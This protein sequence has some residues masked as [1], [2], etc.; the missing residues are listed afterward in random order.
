MKFEYSINKTGL[1]IRL[2][3]AT[4]FTVSIILLASGNISGMTI[5]L[6]EPDT[7][8]VKVVQGGESKLK[9]EDCLTTLIGPGVNQ[10]DSFP[11]W[12]GFVGWVSPVR[13]RNGDWVVGFSAGYWHASAPT[14]L[15]YSKEMI[16]SYIKLG[17]P[18]NISAPSGGR[19]MAIKSTDQGK[20]WSKPVTILDTPDDDRH[21]SFIEL[22]DGTLLCS[23]FT[24]SGADIASIR[25]DPSVSNHTAIIRSFDHGKTWEKEVI[26]IP[27]PFIS[28]ETDGP[29]VLLKDG[30]VLLT[31][32][33]MPEESDTEQ[34]AVFTSMDKGATW[35]L[36][37]TIKA[38]KK[39]KEVIKSEEM[40]TKKSYVLSEGHEL[41]E[42]NTAVLHNGQWV[43]MA[44]P[45]GDICW[46][47]DQGQ[48]WT[49]PVSFGMRMFAPS[50]YVLHDGTLVCLHGSYDPG[51]WG[52]RVIF[53]TDGGHTW[54]APSKSHGFLVS[55]CYGY[56]KA[57]ELPDGS[58][59]IVDQDTGGHRSNDARNMSIRCLRLVIRTDHSGIDLLPL[60][61]Y[62]GLSQ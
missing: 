20:T 15:R 40:D 17:M 39:L 31:I 26:R 21:P 22:S 50:L 7:P 49:K 52:L 35:N 3:N 1:P 33:G 45:E 5:T 34:A 62:P 28:D 19:A 18:E 25:K 38:G 44:R 54:I 9:P 2:F 14:P 47:S 42:T 37:A 30:S 61:D 43:M 23:V 55:N 8:K 16:E 56:A 24:Y 53:S 11:G 41:S 59:F 57:M 58:L 36:L 10:P 29:M 13:L 46:S 4:L 32:N 27:S 60:P 6:Q 51:F 48:N 12:G